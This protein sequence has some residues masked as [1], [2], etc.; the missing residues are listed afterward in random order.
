MCVCVALSGSVPRYLKFI[1]RQVWTCIFFS[2][3]CLTL[4]SLAL[5]LTLP[6]SPSLRSLLLTPSSLYARTPAVPD[7]S[8]CPCLD[9]TAEEMDKVNSQSKPNISPFLGPPH[10]IKMAGPV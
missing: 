8:L 6:L 9:G 7:G 4:K 10:Q 2:Y 1:D 5:A 3:S